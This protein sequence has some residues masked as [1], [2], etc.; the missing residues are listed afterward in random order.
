LGLW[1]K[2]EKKQMAYSQEE[3][4][5]LLQEIFTKI[6]EEGKSLRSI[7]LLPH[8]PE[9]QT[10]YKWIDADPEKTQQYARAMS[11]RADFFADEI[12]EIA[13]TQNADA[14][15][16]DEGRTIIDGQAIQRSKLMVDTRKWLM[17]KMAPKK[18]GEASLL[19]LADNDGNQL[20]INAIFNKDLLD[21]QTDDGT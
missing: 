2:R 10:F 17:G 4:N 11:D 1:I 14:Y 13:D 16:D 20:K 8:M 5:K 7:L 12:L 3:R 6:A 21:V 18:Y 19:K 9:A 15:T